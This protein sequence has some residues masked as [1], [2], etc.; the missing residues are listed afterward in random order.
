M[1]TR[2]DNIT[3]CEDRGLALAK[4]EIAALQVTGDCAR[5][6][7]RSGVELKCL[8]V[9]LQRAGVMVWDRPPIPA[10]RSAFNPTEVT[11]RPV[12]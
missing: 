3:I 5:V 12:S 10:D 1:S 7:L 2:I 6:V 11:L 9:D 4:N 8:V